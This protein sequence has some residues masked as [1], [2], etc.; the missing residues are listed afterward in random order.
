MF[1]V[2]SRLLLALT[3]INS[4]YPHNNSILFYSQRNH[5]TKKV[6]RL[7]QSLTALKVPEQGFKPWHSS[8][9]EHAFNDY[10]ILPVT[11]VQLIQLAKE[12]RILRKRYLRSVFSN[13]ILCWQE[14]HGESNFECNKRSVA[15]LVSLKYALLRK[16]YLCSSPFGLLFTACLPASTPLTGF[17]AFLW[18]SY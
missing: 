18:F 7:T 12:L 10:I 13:S 1:F 3:N 5:N 11:K 4:F 15:Q 8:Y 16:L 14:F 6:N 9:R 17:E 2:P